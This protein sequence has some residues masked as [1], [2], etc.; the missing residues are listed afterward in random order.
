MSLTFLSLLPPY[1]PARSRASKV[2]L[3]KRKPLG[4]NTTMAKKQPSVRRG[5]ALLQELKTLAQRLGIRVREEK[6]FRE[7]GYRARGGSCRVHGQ[8]MVFL[9]RDLSLDERLEILLDEISRREVNREE[10]SPPLR[11]LLGGGA[12]P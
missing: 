3:Y 8:E 1:H 4:H 12:A 9:N 6:L 5:A 11:R 2:V 7:V 10:V